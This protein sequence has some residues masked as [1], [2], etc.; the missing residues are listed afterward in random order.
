MSNFKVG[1]KVV[2]VDPGEGLIKGKIYTVV[3]VLFC[4]GCNAPEVVVKE[5]TREGFPDFNVPIYCTN[6]GTTDEFQNQYYAS[7]FR[8][9][10]EQ[11]KKISNVIDNKEVIKELVTEK[12][13][14]KIK[15]TT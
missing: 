13:D 6:C 10:K 1:Q 4:T 7:R 14:V 9:L 2:C 8:P 15:E 3:K 11:P 5:S 12:S